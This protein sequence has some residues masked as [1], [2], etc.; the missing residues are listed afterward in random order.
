MPP[1]KIQTL[2]GAEILSTLVA[3]KKSIF[4]TKVRS[5]DSKMT[6]TR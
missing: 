2:S 6:M 3:N 1:K 5:I 4:A